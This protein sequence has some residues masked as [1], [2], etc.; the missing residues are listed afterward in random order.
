MISLAMT[1]SERARHARA[2]L[3]AIVAALRV[4]ELAQLVALG[5]R[6]LEHELDPRGTCSDDSRR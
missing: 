4:D 6:L 3:E 1:P 5:R 2:E